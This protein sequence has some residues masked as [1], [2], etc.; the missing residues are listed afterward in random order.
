[1]LRWRSS[2]DPSEAD[3]IAVHASAA[4]AKGLLRLEELAESRFGKRGDVG[5]AARHR[6]L[7]EA[8]ERAAVELHEDRAVLRPERERPVR[9]RFIDGAWKIESPA[10]RLTGVERKALRKALRKTENATAESGRA[11]PLGRG[12]ECTGGP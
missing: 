10:K 4:S 5:I 12:E 7:L 1:M 3:S 8:V 2:G 9:L 11:H 6:R